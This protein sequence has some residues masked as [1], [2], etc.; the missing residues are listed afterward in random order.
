MVGVANIDEA[1]ALWV[2]T[3]GFDLV[4]ER[5]GAD[6]DLAALLGTAPENIV[7]QSLVRTDNAGSGML[8]FIEWSRPG[9]TVRGDANAFDLCT[10]NLD[11]YVDDMPQ[12]FADVVARGYRPR[13]E[14]YS[15]VTAPDGTRFREAHLPVHDDINVVLLQ[16]LDSDIPCTARGFAGVGPLILTVP[17]AQ[18]GQRFAE[19]VLGLGKQ[20]DNLLQGPEIE[21]MIGLPPGTAIDVSVWALPDSKLGQL[22][23]IEYRGVSGESLY[24]RVAPMARG[25]LYIN[26][27]VSDLAALQSRLGNF[28]TAFEDHGQLELLHGA[29]EV[30]SFAMPGGPRIFALG[31]PG[32]A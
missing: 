13:N 24:P 22:E 31:E 21:Q 16:L 26:Y 32:N 14:T 27:K 23:L 12:R 5:A 20:H 9:P 8:H 4:T 18:A 17:S 15:E 29:G 19:E 25:L 28:G 2:D 7:R 3:F 6:P 1:H 30:I 10:K 11:I